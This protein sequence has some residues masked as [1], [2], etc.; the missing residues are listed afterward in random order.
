MLLT[1]LFISVNTP[2]VQDFIKQSFIDYLNIGINNNLIIENSSFNI[3]GE[4][5][6]ND[7]Y[8]SSKDSDTLLY[9]ETLKTN[10]LPLITNS[11]LD[12]SLSIDGLD[13]IIDIT[14]N[15]IKM[16]NENLEQIIDEIFFDRLKVINSSIIIKNDSIQ[17]FIKIDNLVA[18]E[19]KTNDELFFQ[20][21]NFSG[22]FNET[23][24]DNFISEIT[25]DDLSFNLTDTNLKFED[26]FINGDISFELD[27][28][29]QLNRFKESFFEFY[30]ESDNF[31]F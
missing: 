29:Y 26:Q 12:N 13:L 1:I 9:L 28:K 21:S 10:F 25:Y 22:E 8:L 17:N 23:K 6:F 20:L 11:N 19:I 2:K 4:V 14:G 24:V 15:E 7:I 30:L 31:Q 27:S 3:N 18:Q 16:Q 5:V